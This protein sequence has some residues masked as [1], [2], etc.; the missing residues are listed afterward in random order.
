MPRCGTADATYRTRRWDAHRDGR[1][2][3]VSPAG[4]LTAELTDLLTRLGGTR[5]DD[6]RYRRP[7][8]TSVQVSRDA[9]ER[10]ETLETGVVYLITQRSQV[11]IL[12]PLPRPEARSHQVPGLLHEVCK[13]IRKRGAGLR[14][15]LARHRW[16]VVRPR[17]RP[18]S[19]PRTPAASLPWQ[20]S[21]SSPWSSSS[22]YQLSCDV[23]G[24]RLAVSKAQPVA[25]P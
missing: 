3:S 23:A 4:Q 10:G 5:R 15:C 2:R 22:I 6:V 20:S 21:P 12:P 24:Y 19:R 18:A 14:P 7:H 13:R 1:G 9:P 8:G 16:P 11:Q 25:G 17:R